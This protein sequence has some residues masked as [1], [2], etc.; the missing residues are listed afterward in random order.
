MVNKR[1]CICCGNE[2]EYCSHCGEAKHQPRWKTNYD[3]ESCH[4]AF[5]TVT[6]YLAGET[7]KEA[8]K[9]ILS[10]TDLKYRNQYVPSVAKYVDEI[11]DGKVAENKIDLNAI[12]NE[13][14][15]IKEETKEESKEVSK[16][17]S[18]EASKSNN[19]AFSKKENKFHKSFDYK[20]N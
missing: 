18:K 5:Q 3:D 9:V 11:L 20:K 12:N 13:R 8:A 14:I 19:E 6:D 16:E 17:E 15:V 2:Y 4:I 10:N 7:T 1:I